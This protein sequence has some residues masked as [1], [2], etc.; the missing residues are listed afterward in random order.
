M[1]T[2]GI[3]LHLTFFVVVVVRKQNT[4]IISINIEHCHNQIVIR[5]IVRNAFKSLTKKKRVSNQVISLHWQNSNSKE[6]KKKLV[7]WQERRERS[8]KKIV[9]DML[10]NGEKR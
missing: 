3:F 6:G 5:R 8:K 2:F 10:F 4:L 9:F 1:F 7:E